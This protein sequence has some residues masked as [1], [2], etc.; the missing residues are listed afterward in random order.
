MTDLA[1]LQ[2]RI[3]SLEADLADRRL[4]GLA[5]SGARAERAT[6]GLTASFKRF[7]GPAAA[8]AGSVAALTKLTNVTR[9]FDVLNAQLITATGNAKNAS[10]AFEAI[11]D[12]AANTPYDLGQVTDSFTKLVNL[13]LT[14]SEAALTS[15]GNTASAMGKD[16][17]QLIEAVADAATGE[18]ERLKEFGI[19]TKS[20]GDNVS[21]TFRGVTTTVGKNAAE[22]EGYLQDLGNNEFAG[23]MAQ[24]LDTLDGAISNLGDE[25]NKLWLNVSDQ[26]IGDVI[27]DSVRIAIDILGDLNDMLSSGEA[28]ALLDALAG[29]FAGFGDDVAITL[30]ILTE[31][32][33]D[34]LGTPEGAGVAGA[35]SETIQFLIEAFKNLPENIRAV[36]QLMAVEIAALVDYGSEYGAAFGEV[37]GSEFAKIVEKSKA[38]GTAIGEALNPFADNN[39][40]LEGELRR[41]DAVAAEIA[42]TAFAR[43]EQRVRI[44]REA[45]RA[46]IES[47]L[48]ERQA[49]LDSFDTQIMAADKLRAKYDEEMAARKAN[50]ADRLAGFGQGGGGDGGPTPAELKAQ[51]ARE[52]E[53]ANLRLS[54][55]SEEEVIQES[56]DRRLAIILTNTEEGSRQQAELKGR[57]D[58]EFATQALGNFAAPDT[59]EEQL[60]AINDY[61]NARRELILSNT[62]LTEE[63]RTALEL[64]LTAQ[65]NEQLG[66]LET[67]RQQSIL[68]GGAATFGALAELTKT[69]AGE[70]SKEY[71]ALFAV[72][73]AFSIAQTIMKTYES[74]QSAYAA[75]A[76]IPF[77]G[78]ALGAAAAGAAVAVGAAN[79]AQVKSANF[80]GAFDNGGIIPTGSIGLVGEF[81]PELV[82][83][84]ANVRSRR[85]TAAM[86]NEAANDT[87]GL[88]T[89]AV[90]TPVV[91]IINVL[92]P[93]LVAQYM[94]SEEGE[95][96]ILNYITANPEAV[97][98]A[99]NS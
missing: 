77:V 16:L 45:R 62:A 8:A 74:A 82:E 25:W 88:A 36:V 43:A 75:L 29:K 78:P 26:G 4:S 73:Q 23:A 98:S 17:N 47:I 91:K 37:L 1:S 72:S 10:I 87:Q 81:G 90:P 18:F 51:E 66:A 12:F 71:K 94:E 84:P 7:A 15:Y 13:G 76:P 3:Q 57:L 21:F 99:V 63:Q 2:I 9:E 6:D 58:A 59:F 34:F 5:T 40:D 30:E 68:Q 64:E 11:Q 55:R 46:S 83:G 79:V 54:L 35:T 19:K 93:S 39:F 27:E 61:H 96:L 33:N 28:G 42:D 52:K 95:D 22:I 48:E 86:F 67:A 56:Y 38:Y 80:S 31:I 70:Q 53:F 69:F 44:S 49:A 24:R 50:T 97:R 32:W 14:P 92:D 89:S 60:E 20:E 65:R 41:L 85:E